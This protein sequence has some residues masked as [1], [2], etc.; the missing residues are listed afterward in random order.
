[1]TTH[2]HISMH[3]VYPTLPIQ[4]QCGDSDSSELDSSGLVPDTASEAE[5]HFKKCKY[6]PSVISGYWGEP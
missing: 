4:T 5:P 6:L 3:Y 2:A 1:M